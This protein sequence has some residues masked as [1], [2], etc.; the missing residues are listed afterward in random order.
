MIITV[1]IMND[2][3]RINGHDMDL[4]GLLD[5][6]PFY[7]LL[8]DSDHHIVMANKAA[9]SM[10]REPDK[11]IGGYCPK[12]IHNIDGPFAFC[13]L[14][15]AVQKDSA[16]E[17]EFFEPNHMK[18]MSSAIY[19]TR[20]ETSEGKKI[21]L[22]FT[23]DI[24]DKKNA[25]EKLEYLAYHDL[26][27]GLP[28]R[29]LFSDRL[30]QAIQT[31]KRTGKNI[32][33]MS[34]DIDS[35]KMINSMVGYGQG[36]MIIKE[37]AAR[38]SDRLRSSD[39]VACIGSDKF[40]ILAQNITGTGSVMTVAEKIMNSFK[41]PFR[42]NDQEIYITASI[43]VSLFPVDGADDGS[44]IKNADIALNK[45]KENGKNQYLFCSPLLKANVQKYMKISNNLYSALERNE[46]VIYYQPQVSFNTKK[47]IGLEA[48]LRWDNP[49]MGMIPPKDFIPAAEQT[50]LIIPMGDWVLRNACLQN[51][52]WQ[53]AGLPHIR[54]AVNISGIQFQNPHIS[55]HIARILKETELDPEYLELEIT[56]SLAMKESDYFIKTIKDLR[57]LGI[58]ISID[59]FGTEYSSLKYLK[60][61]PVTRIK[62]AMPFIQGIALNEK[63]EAITKTI[64]TI[65]NNLG[66]SVIAEGVETKQQQSFLIDHDCY[67]MQG[68]Y[69]YKPMPAEKIEIL[70]KED[71]PIDFSIESAVS[72]C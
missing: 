72:T 38:L 15:E 31:A 56:E 36:D 39:T 14:E 68:F 48:L 62:I 22:H 46:L 42:L 6:F 71:K 58:M 4:Q 35:F 65:A 40:M 66:M 26:L 47:I 70:L 29:L 43:G 7:V 44:L 49:E 67:E 37:V 28:N 16:V 20:Y 18:W 21:Y 27:T 53:D 12:V 64:I 32:G 50:G 9:V 55:E 19:P 11:M 2:M 61:L 52:A 51:K 1:K 10:C 25:Q 34:L 24:T 8:V 41:K 30:A 54:M 13:P 17:R 63:D 45:A 60:Q 57:K 33:V 23:H 69:Y 3:N 59:D 5:S